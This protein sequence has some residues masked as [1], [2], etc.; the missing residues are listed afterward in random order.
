MQRIGEKLLGEVI[1]D[2]VQEVGLEDRLRA[3]NVCG[4]W[5]EVAGER[6]AAATGSIY[7]ADGILYCRM[8]SSIVRNSVYYSLDGI[9]AEMNRR[10]GKGEEVRKIVLR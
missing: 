7:F 9:R 5:R 1:R 3:V 8:A 6:V 2:Y 4:M 10:L